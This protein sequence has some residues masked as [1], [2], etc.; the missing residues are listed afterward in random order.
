[1]YLKKILH[2]LCTQLNLNAAVKFSIMKKTKEGEKDKCLEPSRK[3]RSRRR[4]NSTL[5]TFFPR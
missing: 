2:I 1:M 5:D 3:F 4:P